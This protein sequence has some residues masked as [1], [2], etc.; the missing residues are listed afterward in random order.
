MPLL[1]KFSSRILESSLELE[2][3]AGF[4]FGQ[5]LHVL[6]AIKKEKGCF[7]YDPVKEIQLAALLQNSIFAEKEA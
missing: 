5:W 4:L 7:P 2:I 3:L 6:A 1:A